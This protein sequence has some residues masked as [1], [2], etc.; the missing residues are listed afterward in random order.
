MMGAKF[1]SWEFV[2]SPLDAADGGCSPTPSVLTED[3]E[4]SLSKPFD[5]SSE[6]SALL[7]SPSSLSWGHRRL[8]LQLLSQQ[9]PCC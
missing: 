7:L 4:T 1:E 8:L 9:L 6:A 3:G 2:F 5:L